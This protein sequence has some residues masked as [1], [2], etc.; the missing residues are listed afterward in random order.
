[1]TEAQG[2]I[3]GDG[4]LAVQNPGDTVGWHVQPERQR[5]AASSG[6]TVYQCEAKFRLAC[7]STTTYRDRRRSDP[8]P[9]SLPNEVRSASND[10]GFARRGPQKLDR[11]SVGTS[12]DRRP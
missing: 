5:L 2:R 12:S 8:S 6:S 10:R 11:A 7:Q 4:P 9:T 1:M 3:A